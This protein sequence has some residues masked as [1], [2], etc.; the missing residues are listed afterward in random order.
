L[1][2]GEKVGL[3]R[4]AVDISGSLDKENDLVLETAQ[5]NG[6]LPHYS[7]PGPSQVV[8]AEF[9]ILSFVVLLFAVVV[10]LRVCGKVH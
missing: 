4:G 9:S 7:V 10:W 5:W 6:A 8:L 1:G 3:D 2:L